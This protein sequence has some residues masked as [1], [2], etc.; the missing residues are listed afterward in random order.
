MQIAF[1]APMK[2]PDHPTPSGDRQMAR[3]LIAA[4]RAAGHDV[5]IATRLRSSDPLGDP[6]RQH[7][8]DQL[9]Q[10]LARRYLAQ[11]ERG[12]QP[13]PD[14]WFTYH[15]YYRA[16]DWIGPRV[17]R[18]LNIPYLLAEASLAPK[19]AGGPWDHSYQAARRAVNQAAAI[20]PLNPR[21]ADCLPD[22]AK[23]RDLPPF[24]DLAPYADVRGRRDAFPLDS[25]APWIVVSAM[26][27]R[28]AKLESYRVIAATLN[29]VRAP[30]RLLVIGDGPARAT[31]EALFADL[32]RRNIHFAGELTAPAYSQALACGDLF[33]WPAINEAYG[34]ALLEAQALGLPAL[35][36]RQGGVPAIVEADVTG[37]LAAPEDPAAFA[38]QLELLL[39]DPV[40]RQA[41]GAAARQKAQDQHSLPAASAH[42]NAALAALSAHR[43]ASRDPG[44]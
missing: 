14:A 26:M 29:Q 19:R 37:L 33:F 16:A 18:A 22:K 15:L 3:G 38:R 9:G 13:R 20:F 41:M 2:P 32:P 24:L 21:N 39:R 10:R 5:A 12:L 36:G 30:F 28:R 1:Y 4:L 7:R 42:L 11:V 27:R 43:D 34:M 25:R 6:I 8:L 17:A 23:L 31:V 35:A 40:R 44:A